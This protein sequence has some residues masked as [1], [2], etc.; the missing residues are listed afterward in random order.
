MPHI[1]EKYD[2]TIA[3]FLV[4]NKKVLLVSHPRY[5]K[6]LPPGGHIELDEDPDEALFREILEETGYKKSELKVLSSRPSIRSNGTKFLYTP[7]YID[8]HEANLPHKHIGLIYF[9][10]PKHSQ[11]RL[12]NEHS[13]SRWFTLKELESPE[14]MISNAIKFYCQEAIKCTD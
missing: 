13:D 4:F 10:A 7:N 11:N 6:W 2:F 9:L 12:S 14:Y 3:S 1:H 8:V 5:G